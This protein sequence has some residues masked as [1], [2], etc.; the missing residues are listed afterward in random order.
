M[1]T[2]RRRSCTTGAK[3]WSLWIQRCFS[4]GQD[5]GEGFF[6]FDRLEMLS[7]ADWKPWTPPLAWQEGELDELEEPPHGLADSDVQEDAVHEEFS[8]SD[9]E[10]CPSVDGSVGNRLPALMSTGGGGYAVNSQE[11]QGEPRKSKPSVQS[12]GRKCKHRK[13]GRRLNF[14]SGKFEPTNK[15]KSKV[16]DFPPG[17]EVDLTKDFEQMRVHELRSAIGC[18][19]SIRHPCWEPIQMDDTPVAVSRPPSDLDYGGMDWIDADPEL[20]IFENEE[21]EERDLMNLNWRSEADTWQGKRWI[22]VESVVDSGSAAPVAPP[23]MAPHVQIE[24]S[25]GSKRGQKWTSASKHKLKNLGQQRIHAATESGNPTDVLFQIA[26]V[27]KPLVSV[28][29]VCERGNRV[30]FGKGG[31]V[32]KNVRTAE[33]YRKNGVYIMS[34]WLM[35]EPHSQASPFTRP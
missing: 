21:P 3:S 12:G 11:T 25:E 17:F 5:V 8:D 7:P 32:V 22:K 27:G 16:I 29:A 35:D 19:R 33:F 14:S 31:G 26:E 15:Q 23:T 1:A 4:Y 13:F 2:N 9:Q 10:D 34:L 6:D 20:N 24:E 30:I 28:S 18:L